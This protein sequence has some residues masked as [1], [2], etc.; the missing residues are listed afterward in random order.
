MWGTHY[1]IQFHVQNHLHV[2]DVY[3]LSE[4]YVDTDMKQ[5]RLIE[6]RI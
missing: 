4:K 6:Q 5:H 1:D 3:W 2:L